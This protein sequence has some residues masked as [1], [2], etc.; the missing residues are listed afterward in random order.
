[1]AKMQEYEALQT[2]RRSKNNVTDKKIYL[3]ATTQKSG[4]E[5]YRGVHSAGLKM[6]SAVDCLVNYFGYQIVY[7]VAKKKKGSSI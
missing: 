6:W 1:M 7:E 2:I 3:A 4:D 5:E